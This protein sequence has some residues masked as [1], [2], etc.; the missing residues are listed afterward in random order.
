MRN[1]I[2]NQEPSDPQLY[3]LPQKQ[4]TH[5]T[6]VTAKAIFLNIRVH[7][8]MYRPCNV[9]K[10]TVQPHQNRLILSLKLTNHQ[11]LVVTPQV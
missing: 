1:S 8:L 3:T 9:Y 7:V 5:S 4:P 11:I 2:S 10:T 6:H